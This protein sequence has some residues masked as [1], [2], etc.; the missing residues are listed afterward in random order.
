MVANRGEVAV[1]VIRALRELE[2]PSV[3]VYSE[4]DRDA[5]HVRLADE[6]VAIGPPPAAQSYLDA[7]AVLAAA[8]ASGCEALHPGYGFL[9]ENAAF[10][11]LCADAGVVFVGPTPEAIEA[12]GEKTRA[13][14]LATR[15]GVPVVPGSAGPVI[16]LDQALEVADRVGYPLA[17][18]A[19]GGGGGIGF[20]VVSSHQELE[21]T[22]ASV[23]AD[24]ERFFGNETVYVERY[25]EDPRHVEIQVLGDAHGTLVQLGLRDCSV[26]RR[27]QKLVEESPAPTVD[28]ALAERLGSYALEL[29]RAIDYTSAGT[30]EGLLVDEDFYFLEMNT[31]L[32]VEHPVTEL[33]TGIDL[34]QEQL[35]IAAGRPLSFAQDDVTTRGV[36][37]E[38]RINAEAA[39]RQFLPSPGTIDSYAEPA[40]TGV[41]VDSG[42]TAGTVVSPFYDSLLAKVVT[43]GS[44]REEATGLM[45]DAL[46]GFVLGG[47]QSLIPFHRQLLRTDQ[48]RGAE[49]CRDLLGDRAWLKQTAPAERP[50]SG[51]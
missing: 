23:S 34:V 47:I 33:V 36:A 28:A 3:A 12:M 30:I 37:I 50:L 4:A 31:R 10:A 42:V 44:T 41:R 16:S 24:G 46:D 40:G 51:A 35:R 14:E 32:Q 22:L 38:C 9:S 8:R 6:A 48:W 5:P 7:G 21:A 19:S 25:F 2:I 17:V 11:R 15:L 29:A 49:T 39:H 45:I 27:H 43:H 18:K 20:R 26:Q 13:R 1:R